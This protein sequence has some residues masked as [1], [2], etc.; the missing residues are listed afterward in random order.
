M[1]NKMRAQTAADDSDEESQLRVGK[2]TETSSVYQINKILSTDQYAV[3][4]NIQQYL[5]A[6][7]LQYKSIQESAALLPQPMEGIMMVVNETVQSFNQEHNLGKEMG[8]DMLYYCRPTVEKYI[9]SKLFDQLFAMY[10]H[11]NEQDD[12]LFTERSLIIK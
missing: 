1:A 10:Q 4:S 3:G 5:E 9:F 6:F 11:K 12:E 8:K 2:Y 7:E